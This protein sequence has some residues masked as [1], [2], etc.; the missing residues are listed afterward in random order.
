MSLWSFGSSKRSQPKATFMSTPAP[1]K[2]S[3]PSKAI[4]GPKFHMGLK[5]DNMSSIGQAVNQKRGNPGPH[6]DPNLNAVKKKLP[7]FTMAVRTTTQ[8]KKVVPAP[9]AYNTISYSKKKAPAFSFGS[10]A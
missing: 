3:L 8:N 7:A 5:L 10:A 6:Y 9:G 1:T 4:E 2:Y